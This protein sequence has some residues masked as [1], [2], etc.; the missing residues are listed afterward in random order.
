MHITTNKKKKQKYR[1]NSYFDELLTDFYG[2]ISQDKVPNMYLPSSDLA[3]IT[4]LLNHK[5][6]RK[7]SFQQV[8]K[9]LSEEKIPTTIPPEGETN[10]GLCANIDRVGVNEDAA[11]TAP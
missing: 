7:F 3:Y 1:D 6:N 11:R 9:M 5:F 4:S 10:T 8:A 2:F